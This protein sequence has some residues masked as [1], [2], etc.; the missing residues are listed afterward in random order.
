[1]SGP[2]GG[3]HFESSAGITGQDTGEPNDASEPGG[4]R[5]L[6]VQHNDSDMFANET[7]LWQPLGDRF[8]WLLGGSYT[9]NR[10]RLTRTL[11]PVDA[12]GAV[13]GVT[14]V[15][16]EVTLYGEASLRLSDGLVATG[17]ARYTHSRLGGQGE[18]VSP[19]LATTLAAI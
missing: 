14:N 7:R 6:F 10:T 17:G 16:D 19:F 18:D 9:H 15:I 13:T 12:A 11:G 5:R 3:V 8:G 4:R 1:G 2:L